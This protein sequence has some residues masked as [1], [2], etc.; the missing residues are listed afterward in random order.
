MITIVSMSR[1]PDLYRDFVKQA[2]SKMGSLID[3]YLVFVNDPN[4]LPFYKNLEASSSKVKVY[5]APEDFVYKHGHDK[6]YNFL[7]SKVQSTFILKLFDTDEIVVNSKLLEEE[8]KKT[9]LDIY[10]MKT[11]MQR[12]DVWEV[13]YQLYRKGVLRWSGLVHENQESPTGR[14]MMFWPGPPEITKSTEPSLSGKPDSI[15][16]VPDDGKSPIWIFQGALENLKI[17]H[18]NALDTFSSNLKKTDDGFIILE[19]TPEGTDSDRRNLLYESLAWRIVN[20]DLPHSAKGWFQR[21]Y[22]INKEVIDWYY[23]RAKKLYKL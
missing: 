22:Q 6:V 5:S 16:L 9:N 7:E 11:W 23:D 2:E 10:G 15:H 21:H 3:N 1:R 12:G 8:I 17:L 14:P 20:E 19:K 4:F 18:H 13:K